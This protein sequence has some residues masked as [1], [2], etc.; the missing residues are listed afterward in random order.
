MLG[1]LMVLCPALGAEVLFVGNSYTAYHD[2]SGRLAAV[3]EAASAEASTDQLTG[4]GLT[5]AD[6]ASRASD[7]GGDWYRKLVSEGG[8]WSWV[9]LQDQSQIPGFPESNSM[10][11]ASR[12]GAISLNNLVRDTEAE[13]MFF[14]TWGRRSGDPMNEVMYPDFS[15]MQERL[16]AG[17]QS[18]A[19]AVSSL[20]RPVWI[21]PVGPAFLKIHDDVVAAGMEPTE[22][23]NDFYALYSSDGSHPSVLGSQLAAYVFYASLTG[24]SPM[25]LAVPD[26]IDEDT[27]T[28]LQE[29]AFA[30]VFDA[31]DPYTFPWETEVVEDSGTVDTALPDEETDSGGG[32]D[33]E[34]V[35]DGDTGVL[36][37][38]P[39]E[40]DNDS[41]G[42]EAD[43]T[44]PSSSSSSG[45]QKSESGCSVQNGR[46]AWMTVLISI[47]GVA[48]RRNGKQ[49]SP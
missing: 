41:D 26:G 40:T 30:V 19:A 2:L 8:R 39:G 14:M 29:A 49:L 17:Y 9:I 31:S 20:E 11:M 21:A 24:E 6:H 43:G 37:D 1:F 46:A 13:T 4:G 47:M 32:D 33:E 7:E 16:S 5:L 3:F 27:A 44:V 34:A 12:D 42:S 28:V 25:G 48:F 23:G 18:Y 45:E 15:T 35:S 38:A 10:W 36:D 22:S